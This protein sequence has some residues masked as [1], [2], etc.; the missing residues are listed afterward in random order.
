M[1]SLSSF[2]ILVIALI[3][4]GCETTDRVLTGVQRTVTSRTGQTVLDLAKGKDAAQIAK[5]Q[6]DQYARDPAAVLRDLRAA[7]KDFEALLAALG[8]NVGKTWG[9]LVCLG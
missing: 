6:L 3:I 9:K 4:A 1:A 2:T 7:Q 8:M 5:R